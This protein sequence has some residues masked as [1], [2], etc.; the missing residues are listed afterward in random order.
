MEYEKINLNSQV[1]KKTKTSSCGCKEKG[2]D[3]CNN[4]INLNPECGTPEYFQVTNYFSELVHEW[5]KEAARYNLGIQ[6]LENIEYRTEETEEGTILTK[7]V[8]TYRKGHEIITREFCCAPEGPK[9]KDGK[10]GR[11]G[12]QG[13]RGEKGEKGDAPSLN[14]V[15]LNWVD[16]YTEEGGRFIEDCMNNAYNLELNLKRPD[17]FEELSNIL[18]QINSQLTQFYA[19]KSDLL[20]YVTNTK[21]NEVV[22][23][24]LNKI[25]S[26]GAEY[27][28]EYNEPWLFLTKDGRNVSSVKIKSNSGSSSSYYTGNIIVYQEIDINATEVPSSKIIIGSNYENKGWTKALPEREHE[29]LY[30]VWMATCWV[31][32]GSY[33]EWSYTR[34]TGTNGIDGVDADN[35]E[36]IYYQTTDSIVPTPHLADRTAEKPVAIESSWIDHPEGV[37]E[38]IPYEFYTFSKKVGGEWTDFVAPMIWSHYGQNGHDGDGVEYIFTVTEP[39]NGEVDYPNNPTPYD[40]IHTPQYQKPEWVQDGWYDS[41]VTDTLIFKPG[42]YQF[43]AQRK[44]RTVTSEIVNKYPEYLTYNDIGEKMWLPFSAPSIWSYYSTNSEQS[45]GL[46]GAVIRMR[47]EWKPGIIYYKNIAP[48]GT[49]IK[50]I[51][52]VLAP[53]TDKYYFLKNDGHRQSL[54]DWATDSSYWTL[55]TGFDFIATKALFAENANINYLDSNEIRIW[56]DNSNRNAEH[57]VAGMTSGFNLQEE[58]PVKQQS[59]ENPVRIWAGN[60]NDSGDVDLEK[61]PFKVY[62][63]G[64]IVAN[65]ANITG[66]FNQSNM[67]IDHDVTLLQSDEIGVMRWLIITN[68]GIYTVNTE[69]NY[70]TIKC[71]SGSEPGFTFS[72]QGLYFIVKT[73]STEY[74]IYKFTYATP[75]CELTAISNSNNKSI[76]SSDLNVITSYSGSDISQAQSVNITFTNGEMPTLSQASDTTTTY[77]YSLDNFDSYADANQYLLQYDYEQSYSASSYNNAEIMEFAS[78]FDLSYNIVVTGSSQ[79]ELHINFSCDELHQIINR[80]IESNIPGTYDIKIWEKRAE[81]D[82]RELTTIASVSIENNSTYTVNWAPFKALLSAMNLEAVVTIHGNIISCGNPQVVSQ[83]LDGNVYSDG[84]QLLVVT[85]GTT[86]QNITD[87]PYTIKYTDGK[88]Q[89]IPSRTDSPNGIVIAKQ[90][91]EQQALTAYETYMQSL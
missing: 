46:S 83:L 55:A 78:E 80:I 63:D 47:G 57:L 23:D 64:S 38:E 72:G 26:A 43:V 6:E 67:T 33:G 13:I 15:I 60:V 7:V 34:L 75:N 25:S 37:T 74:I 76:S 69:N 56:N 8:F 50:Y 10:D 5:E 42:S 82:W 39:I 28:L 62:N 31:D 71:E 89:T 61:A 18:N 44:Y 88:Y 81:N 12:L 91:T 70:A 32:A 77:S 21:F 58:D 65:N 29:D 2:R 59:S 3:Y 90:A 11:D 40:T 86:I 49:N 48:S 52:V 30:A 36:F 87:I 24:L 20:S 16:T 73:N 22:S 79:N 51:D 27:R 41:P 68:T 14:K 35:L 17:V 1:E 66:I 19:K 4:K 54:T 9:G 45:Q 53:G 84:G 85:D